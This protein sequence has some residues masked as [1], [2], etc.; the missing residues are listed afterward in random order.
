[1]IKHNWT[2]DDVVIY[3]FFLAYEIM[4]ANIL[5][6]TFKNFYHKKSFYRRLAKLK[7][8]KIL[9]ETDIK[10]FGAPVTEKFLKPNRDYINIWGEK[11]KNFYKKIL[12]KYKHNFFKESYS[13]YWRKKLDEYNMMRF[14]DLYELKLI[15]DNYDMCLI[16]DRF[17]SKKL[18]DK[19]YDFIL[20]SREKD[21]K[22]LGIYDKRKYPG[23]SFNI[24]TKDVIEN[25]EFGIE[26]NFDGMI[27]YSERDPKSIYDFEKIKKAIGITGQ[28][29]KF[30]LF[31]GEY[32][33]I[34]N[35]KKS[36]T[37]YNYFLDFYASKRN[38]KW[39]NVKEVV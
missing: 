27:L 12:D 17:R 24:K 28:K 23:Q 4:S 15:F 32:S 33:S 14:L 35:K 1:M 39:K 21:L 3:Q 36:E 20:E 7:E 6:K 5:Y 13:I 18:E 34:I 10:P 19:D 31:L 26:N 25:I 38:R 16:T 8:A 11:R 22:I 9:I 29:I 30:Q 2:G 37:P